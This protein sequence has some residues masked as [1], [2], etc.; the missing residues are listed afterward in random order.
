L[1]RLTSTPYLVL[2][3]LLGAVGVST[4]YAA[5]TITLAADVKITGDTE[6]DG[7][8]IDTNNEAGTSGQVLSSIE[9]GID[10]IDAASGPQGATGMTGMTGVGLLGSVGATGMTGVGLAGATGMTGAIGMTGTPGATGMTGMTGVGSLDFTFVFQYDTT[11]IYIVPG[12]S[13]IFSFSCPFPLESVVSGGVEELLFET[14]GFFMSES[15]PFDFNTWV[16]R[17]ENTSP[18][19]VDYKIWIVCLEDFNFPTS[20]A[21]EVTASDVTASKAREDIVLEP[22][23]FTQ[24]NKVR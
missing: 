9:T 18:F 19:I 5:I 13:L 12:E 22:I 17:V 11:D 1:G 4:A 16:V 10:W 8:L 2:F 21:T 7:K 14:Q 3:I 24:P 6:L 15:Y 20:S 23:P